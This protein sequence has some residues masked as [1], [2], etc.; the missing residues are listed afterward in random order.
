[1]ETAEVLIQNWRANDWNVVMFWVEYGGCRMASYWLE[2]CEDLTWKYKGLKGVVW[3]E[4]GK[5]LFYT[6]LC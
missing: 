3:A 4:N 1:M 5:D 2:N 6:G